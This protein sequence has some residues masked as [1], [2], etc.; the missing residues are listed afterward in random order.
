[1][2]FY[3]VNELKN[4]TKA[5]WSSLARG[6]VVITE[7]GKP[8][9]LMMD[10]KTRDFE[11]TMNTIRQARAILAVESMRR[12]AAEMGYMTEEEIEAEIAASRRERREREEG[13][14][15]DVRGD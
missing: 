3:S 1:M 11:K 12:R 10:V 7:D 2:E 15:R 14:L 9:A 6:E 8:S 5:V 4:N 13:E